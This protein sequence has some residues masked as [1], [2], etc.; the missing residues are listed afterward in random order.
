MK[1]EFLEARISPK[2]TSTK[3]VLVCFG[4]TD[5]QNYSEKI[6]NELLEK[7]DKII[8]LI[9]YPINPNFK[10]IKEIEGKNPERLKV[11]ESL[12][13]AQMTEVILKNDIAILQPS[14]IALEAASLGIYIAL[15]Q[16][17]DNQKYIC[18][19]LVSKKC[20]SK[21]ENNNVAKALSSVSAEE[22]NLQIENQGNIFDKKSPSR[23]LNIFNSLCL[24]VRKANSED[25][26]LLFKWSNDKVTRENSYNKTEIE[27]SSHVDWFKEKLKD[28][29]CCF[30][31]VEYNKTPAA[32]VR[33]DVKPDENSIGITVA[34]EFRGQKLSSLILKKADDYFFENFKQKK[35]CHNKRNK[36]FKR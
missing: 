15:I 24:T 20:A 26:D 36:Y 1:K 3:N 10:N 14:N 27:Y 29:N 13:T 6:V 30:L 9:T 5:P 33:M 31:I 18:D 4:G 21:I 2:K 35:T 16:T 8:N 7:T 28:A 23:I 17:A 12:T 34:P 11:L 19:T 22:I 25:V 32:T